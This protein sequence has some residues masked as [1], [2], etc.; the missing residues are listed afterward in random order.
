MNLKNKMYFDNIFCIRPYYNTN[1]SR[2]LIIR[3]Q[4]CLSLSF[5][6]WT[7]HRLIQD[8]QELFRISCAFRIE[9]IKMF[10]FTIFNVYT[11]TNYCVYTLCIR[12]NMYTGDSAY[13]TQ[14]VSKKLVKDVDI[15]VKNTYLC[16]VVVSIHA[17]FICITMF[18]AIIIV[19]V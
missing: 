10:L 5:H 17:I 8:I 13:K 12:Y 6:L 19:I 18:I 11:T 15:L 9:T 16:S 1:V 7:C 14:Q 4:K 2:Y 3:N